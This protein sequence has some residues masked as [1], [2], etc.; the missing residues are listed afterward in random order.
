[1]LKRLIFRIC[2]ADVLAQMRNEF[3]ETMDQ[4][5]ISWR[6]V[7]EKLVNDEI[8]F[9]LEEDY[10]ADY[11]VLDLNPVIDDVQKPRRKY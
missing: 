1:M 8:R 10:Y 11:I 7:S 9:Q 4:L 6:K 5:N 3:D 2:L